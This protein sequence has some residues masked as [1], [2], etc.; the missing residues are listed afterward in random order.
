M[1]LVLFSLPFLL[2]LF[3]DEICHS[4]FIRA[5]Q[6]VRLYLKKDV[7]NLSTKIVKPTLKNSLGI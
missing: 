5:C 2:R 3:D 7:A 1:M 4:S 6:I